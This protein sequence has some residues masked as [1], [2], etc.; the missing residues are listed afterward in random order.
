MDKDQ[1]E[2]ELLKAV[3]HKKGGNYNNMSFFYDP[4]DKK[5]YK[6]RKDSC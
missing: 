4:S 2:S 6:N 5:R 1:D 3:T